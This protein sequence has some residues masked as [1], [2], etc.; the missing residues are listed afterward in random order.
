MG[1]VIREAG[2]QLKLAVDALGAA[3]TC[4]WRVSRH[5][6]DASQSAICSSRGN[7]WLAVQILQTSSS[8]WP[9]RVAMMMFCRLGRALACGFNDSASLA[10]IF[11]RPVPADVPVSEVAN[12]I[13]LGPNGKL[14]MNLGFVDSV[15]SSFILRLQTMWNIITRQAQLCTL[16]QGFHGAI[17]TAYRIRVVVVFLDHVGDHV[18]G[19]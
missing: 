2:V 5:A 15:A 14:R 19:V 4:G 13:E 11:R 17:T 1:E 18:R 7:N 9:T 10:A 8:Q 16:N 12:S 3:E 6:L